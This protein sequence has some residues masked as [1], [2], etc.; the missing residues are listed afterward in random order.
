MQRSKEKS[1]NTSFSKGL[2]LLVILVLVWFFHMGVG[3][4]GLPSGL[5]SLL[6]SDFENYRNLDQFSEQKTKQ[7]QKELAD[8][9]TFSQGD[10]SSDPI[11]KKEWVELIDNGILW[12]VTKWYINLPSGDKSELTHIIQGFVSPHSYNP[13]DSMYHCEAHTIRQAFIVDKDTCYGQSHQDEMWEI[14][15]NGDK[16]IINKR[17]YQ[18]YSGDIHEFYPDNKL[19]D[20]VDRVDIPA[21]HIGVSLSQLGKQ[22]LAKSFVPLASSGRKKAVESMIGTYYKPMVIDEITRR[23]DPRGV[24]EVMDLDLTVSENGTV[25]SVKN[26]TARLT[27]TRFDEAVIP[28]VKSWVFPS[29]SA[30]G[31][32]ELYSLSIPVLPEGVK[33]GK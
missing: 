7:V 18:K 12:Q 2:I 26:K 31:G 1:K 4:S 17:E 5:A 19:I 9:W 29:L 20:Q 3:K 6:N 13:V 24:P 8:F 28:D 14:T 32:P 21:C 27:T 23:Y 30:K 33:K 16:L 25:Q 15:R 22:V 10:P 11:S